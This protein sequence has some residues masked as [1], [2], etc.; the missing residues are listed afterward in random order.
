ME[1]SHISHPHL[2]IR[3]DRMQFGSI[4]IF[5]IQREFGPVIVLMYTSNSK[6]AR[7]T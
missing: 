2:I 3:L 6:G 7:P 1:I 4:R 5:S